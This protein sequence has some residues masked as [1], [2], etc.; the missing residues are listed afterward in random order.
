MLMEEEEQKKEE[1]E[2]KDFEEGDLPDQGDLEIEKLRQNDSESEKLEESDSEVEE[3]EQEGENQKPDSFDDSQA[4]KDQINANIREIE[5]KQDSQIMWAIFLMASVLLIIL[6]VPYIKSNYFDKFEYKGLEFQKTRIGD[7][8]FYS[9]KFPVVSGT[10]QVIGDYAVNLRNDPRDLEY[11]PVNV[12]N[13]TIKFAKH[14]GGYGDVYI[15]V[16]DSITDCD[17]SIIAMA[18][19]SGFLGDSGLK[20]KSGVLNKTYAKENNQARINCWN[21]TLDTV[22]KVRR[23][24]KTEIK[25]AKENCYEIIFKDCEILQVSEKFELLILEQYVNS[26]SENSVK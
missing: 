5:K 4:P 14:T 9:V 8:V 13:D 10:G 6:L 2:K 23:G 11:I 19:L 22:I 26:L 25:E 1:F 18:T 24:E 15:S 12:T 20:V 21:S 3:S 7:L 17:D 16:G